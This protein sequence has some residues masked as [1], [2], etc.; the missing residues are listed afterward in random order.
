MNEG[1]EQSEVNRRDFLKNTSAAAFMAMMGGVELT[2][3]KA[4]AATGA[5]EGEAPLSQIPAVPAVNF[6]VIGAGT[7]GRKIITTLGKM[8]NTDQ[9]KNAKVTAICDSYP[10]ALKKAAN[11][12][13]GAQDLDDYK[14]LL[15]MPEVDAVVVATPTHLH[16]DI[17]IDAL[18]AGKHV[19]SE[20]PLAGSI[21][22]AK[23]I[24]RAAQGAFKQFFQAGLVERAS[25]QRHF[26]QGFFRAGALARHVFVRAQSHA[27]NSW[28]KTDSNAARAKELNWRL[29]AATS[30]GLMGEACINLLDSVPWYLGGAKQGGRP[31]AVTGFSSLVLWDDGRTVPDTVQCIFE[32]PKGPNAGVRFI[33]DATLCNHYES[34]CELYFG[35]DAAILVQPAN[36]RREGQTWMF[37]EADAAMLGWEPYAI[38]SGFGSEVGISLRMNA[39]KQA[40]Q[41]G[42]KTTGDTPPEIEPLQYALQSFMANSGK[43]SAAVR[44]WE[45]DFP[46]T[47][48]PE[49]RANLAERRKFNLDEFP[50]AGWQEGLEATVLAIKANE[51]AVGHKRIDLPKELFEL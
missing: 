15:A 25:P 6:G 27:K 30:T 44:D 36:E 39:S 11:A 41:E 34:E 28:R 12:V 29:D 37:K 51:A 17:V 14:K 7:W 26:I 47:D 3:P 2:A 32:F 46:P 16:R 20:M 49:Y 21:D 10:A 33:C 50:A 38:H 1:Q 43:L 48:T 23:A 18:Q 5:G 8:S 22:D 31:N 45:T 42:K 19:Y 13:A 4:K 9:F 24:A 40:A 35:S